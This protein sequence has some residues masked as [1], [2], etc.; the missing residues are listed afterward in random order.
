MKDRLARSQGPFT[1][2]LRAFEA[3]PAKANAHAFGHFF[4][5]CSREDA[6][7]NKRPFIYIELE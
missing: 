5:I 2:A 1:L 7:A 6:D 3:T 4:V